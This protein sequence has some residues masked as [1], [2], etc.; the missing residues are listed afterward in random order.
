MAA[1]GRTVA[2]STVLL[3]A[4]PITRVTAFDFNEVGTRITSAEDNDV[5]VSGQHVHSVDVTGSI[6]SRDMAATK[7]L[8]AGTSGTVLTATLHDEDGTTD[9]SV[10]IGLPVFVGVPRTQG[11]GAFGETT[12]DFGAKSADGSTSPISVS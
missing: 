6:T 7:A 12:V 3:D 8:A 11:Y 2:V 9:L 10:S 5:Y 1:T 4:V